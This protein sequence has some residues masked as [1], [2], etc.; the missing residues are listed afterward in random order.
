MSTTAAHI[1]IHQN[2]VER[3]RFFCS[4]FD[5]RERVVPVSGGFD[6]KPPMIELQTEQPARGLMVVSDENAT[7]GEGREML[8]VTC[9]G[10]FFETGC[11]PECGAG[12][13]MAIETDFSIHQLDEA[14]GNG[15]AEAAAAV[16]P[17][18]GTVGLSER[19]E[20]QV[21]GLLTNADAGVLDREAQGGVVFGLSL[22]A[23]ADE[24]FALMGELDGVA[25]E[26]GENLP[27]S[28]GVAA[29]ADGSLCV[30]GAEQL[31]SARVS[32]AGE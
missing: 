1:G 21:A 24:H 28:A 15:K 31:E 23:D 4:S 10:L 18:G 27:E 6:L 12:V 17:C 2:E 22:Y 14:L 25:D 26:V 8:E 5:L 16:F 29:Q 3:Q 20:E 9:V 13:G 11:E 30:D 7:S 19:L 32:G